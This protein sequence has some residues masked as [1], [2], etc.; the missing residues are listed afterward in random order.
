[1]GCRR[2]THP[3]SNGSMS[4]SNAALAFVAVPNR[5]AFMLTGVPRQLAA[6]QPAGLE[7]PNCTDT[8]KLLLVGMRVCLV[9]P[10]CC[11]RA[12]REYSPGHA[13]QAGGPKHGAPQLS[14]QLQQLCRP[15]LHTDS[16]PSHKLVI[17][18]IPDYLK[19]IVGWVRELWLG[20]ETN[21]QLLEP[22]TYGSPTCA[23]LTHSVRAPAAGG[24]YPPEASQPT[25]RL[26]TS[27]CT[28]QALLSIIAMQAASCCSAWLTFMRSCAVTAYSRRAWQS[29]LSTHT[30]VQG[31]HS[32]EPGAGQTSCCKR[33]SP[34]FCWPVTYLSIQVFQVRQQ[35]Q[36]LLPVIGQPGQGVALKAC[37]LQR[38]TTHMLDGCLLL[39]VNAPQQTECKNA[40]PVACA[41]SCCSSCCT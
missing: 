23:C 22:Q 6:A 25:N 37:D 29:R 7:L 28:M 32:H 13:R 10:A 26:L 27:L 2:A 9:N 17:V 3:C 40:P 30:V 8:L 5:H 21:S 41:D 34:S 1:M 24:V 14:V 31:L 18:P 12:Q 39:T 11:S 19:R 33:L 38:T 35:L 15:R 20:P 16:R 36:D 4:R